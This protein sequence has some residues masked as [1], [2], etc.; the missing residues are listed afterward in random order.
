M[1]KQKL[2]DYF[3]ANILPNTC[4]KS[5]EELQADKTT[6]FANAPRA[7]IACEL[8]GVWRGLNHCKNVV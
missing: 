4:F 3:E 7:L 2:K 5:L 1:D 6:V 8:M